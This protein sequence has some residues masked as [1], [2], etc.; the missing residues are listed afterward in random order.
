MH[1]LLNVGL[2]WSLVLAGLFL[3]LIGM[4]LRSMATVVLAVSA[5]MSAVCIYWEKREARYWLIMWSLM[6][7]VA[8]AIS[9]GWLQYGQP[10]PAPG[11]EAACLERAA[12]LEGRLDICHE[13]VDGYAACC[14]DVDAT[15]DHCDDAWGAFRDCSS[16]LNACANAK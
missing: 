14:Q 5:F 8:F 15:L 2:L 1:P 4:D 3:Y 9:V 7:G 13:D 11:S 12:E 6:S 10:P 16:A